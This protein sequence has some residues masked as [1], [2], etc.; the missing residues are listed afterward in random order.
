MGRARAKTHLIPTPEQQT[1]LETIVND[2]DTRILL[3]CGRN[4]GKSLVCSI[5]ALYVVER[6]RKQ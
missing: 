6:A 4:W 3:S 2:I 1:A 5:S